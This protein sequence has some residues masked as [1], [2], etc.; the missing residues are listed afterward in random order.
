MQIDIPGAIAFAPPTDFFLPE[1][2]WPPVDKHPE[3]RIAEPLHPR[4]ILLG[5]LVE[6]RDVLQGWCGNRG[7]LGFHGPRLGRIVPGESRSRNGNRHK[8]G[9]YNI[10]YH[11]VL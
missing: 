6:L 4:R 1:R 11:N 3:L 8:K 9:S 5:G 7:G 2:A 10:F